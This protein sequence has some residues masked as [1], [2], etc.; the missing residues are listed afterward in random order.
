MTP[1]ERFTVLLTVAGMA[2]AL[3]LGVFRLLWTIAQKWASTSNQLNNLAQGI[4]DLVVIKN[5]E[6][7]RLTRSDE[8][9]ERRIA[10][11][12]E[13]RNRGGR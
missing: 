12:E 9:L 7:D 3:L 13:W 10:R 8:K 2:S 6:H 11:I 5:R 1:N 4:A